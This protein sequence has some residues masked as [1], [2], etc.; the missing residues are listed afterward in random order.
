MD[1]VTMSKDQAHATA[2]LADRL[3]AENVAVEETNIGPDAIHV[4]V[5]RKPTGGDQPRKDRRFLIGRVV[6]EG[7]VSE[8]TDRGDVESFD[9]NV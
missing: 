3:D 6:T 9:L 5:S 7:L 8:L 2:V 4:T 1:A